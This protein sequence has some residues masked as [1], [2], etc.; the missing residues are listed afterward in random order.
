LTDLPGIAVPVVY[1]VKPKRLQLRGQRQLLLP[2]L[3]ALVGTAT[4]NDRSAMAHLQA[5]EYVMTPGGMRKCR[6][7]TH[8]Y[9]IEP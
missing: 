3:L 8:L 7:G 5:D 2:S 4:A 9:W 6:A 1:A